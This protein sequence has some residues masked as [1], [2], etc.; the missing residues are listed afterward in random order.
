MAA[1]VEQLCRNTD[2]IC[3][4]YTNLSRTDRAA[5]QADLMHDSE[6]ITELL[7]QRIKDPAGL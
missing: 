1:P 6:T 2:T 7:E 4:D 5:L 3:R